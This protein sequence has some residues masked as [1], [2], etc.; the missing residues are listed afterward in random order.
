MLA[1]QLVEQAEAVDAR[2]HDVQQHQVEA[3]VLHGIQRLGAAG[4][5]VDLETTVEKVALQILTQACVIFGE[6]E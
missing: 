2:Q 5:G 3:A 1:A 4:A 6:K